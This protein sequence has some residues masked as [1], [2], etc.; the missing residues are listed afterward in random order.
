MTIPNNM[1]KTV[2]FVR[3]LK[4]PYASIDLKPLIFV[5]ATSVVPDLQND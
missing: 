5:V 3:A 1:L 4:S 2:V